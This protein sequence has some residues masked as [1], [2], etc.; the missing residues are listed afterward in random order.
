MN[1]DDTFTGD[2]GF[3]LPH[4]AKTRDGVAFDPHASVWSYRDS[5]KRIHMDFREIPASQELI[6]SA[7]LALQWYAENL[8]PS[9]TWNMYYFFS[10]F[11]KYIYESSNNKISNITIENIIS[12]R[13]SLTEETGYYLG[14]LR[15]FLVQWY[16]MGL[17]GIGAEVV[18]LLKKMKI[19]GNRKGHPVLTMDIHKGPLTDIEWEAV[20][21]ALTAS[22]LDG[23]IH[24]DDYLLAWL[25]IALGQR[26][27]QYAAMKLCDFRVVQDE[28]GLNKYFLNIPRAKQRGQVLRATFLERLLIPDIG[29]KLAEHVA[30]TRE[31]F[32]QL[33]SEPENAPMFPEYPLQSTGF[34]K[35]QFHQD[36]RDLSLQFTEIVRMLKV[37]SERTGKPL[38]LSPRRF[39]Y[40][41]GTRMAAEG[42]SLRIIAENLGHS[43]FQN[44]GIYV[45]NAPAFVERIDK[46]TALQFAPLAQA[47]RGEIIANESKAIRKDDPTS[48]V[49]DLRLGVDRP[50]GNCGEFGFCGRFAPLACYTCR[51]FQPWLDGP[52]EEILE[53]ILSER[54]RLEA[55]QDL[56]IASIP[57]RTILAIAYVVK[58]CAMMRNVQ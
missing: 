11:I 43:G 38:R 41:Y 9:H 37:Y 14:S 13:S 25:V 24:L 27:I 19:K 58:Q 32:Q 20:H 52:H 35:F 18:S 2:Y 54:E 42:Y 3:V 36:A 57:D 10:E 53:F 26:P 6:Q 34:G 15:G 29:I 1:N 48:R 39:R 4:Q 40:T 12:F 21:T 47:F 56:R 5:L 23:K 46:A 45:A 49:C 51:R 28:D 55:G 31:K 22:Y 33:L 17:P 16:D 7:K 30:K 44:V 8:S 50:V